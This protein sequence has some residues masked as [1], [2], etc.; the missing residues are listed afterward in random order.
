M[1]LFSKKP[2]PRNSYSC[3]VYP[4]NVFDGE[5]EFNLIKVSF[6]KPGWQWIILQYHGD[7][8]WPKVHSYGAGY[9]TRD[10]ALV[11]LLEKAKDLDGEIVSVR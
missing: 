1:K 4:D 2:K 8:V 6:A 11:D 5:T 7:S 10:A 3:Q 9:T